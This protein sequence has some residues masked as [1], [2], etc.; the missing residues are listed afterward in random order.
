MGLSC[1]SYCIFVVFPSLD[2]YWPYKEKVCIL[3]KKE[4]VLDRGGEYTRGKKCVT[5]CHNY[6]FHASL[7][8]SYDFPGGLVTPITLLSLSFFNL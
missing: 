8:Y 6:L 1:H 4:R 3:S 5:H 2:H 7:P